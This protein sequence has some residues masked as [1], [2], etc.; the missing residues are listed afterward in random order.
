VANQAR[1]ATPPPDRRLTLWIASA[2]VPLP[3]IPPLG[4]TDRSP[5]Q[6][7]LLDTV[8]LNADHIFATLVRAPGLF[9]RWLPFGA[10]LLAGRLPARDRELL[11]LRTAWNCRAGYE[12]GHHVAIG[13]QAGLTRDEIDRLPG[14]PDAA[15]PA[16]DAVLLR[17]ADEL[18]QDHRLSDG[19][20]DL[21][22]TRYD[23]QQL[24]ELPMLVGHYHLVAM[25]LNSLG[26]QLE[27]GYEDL[28]S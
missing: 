10:K 2:G 16:A 20:W 3:R 25:T 5:R 28:P 15:W 17:A 11:I 14:G 9:R 24:I 4:P 27:P 18:H 21:L 26:V 6:Q 19:T 12:W 22:R 23:E 13:L 7:E 1:G 8:Q